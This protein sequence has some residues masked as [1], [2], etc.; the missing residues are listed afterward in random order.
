MF[1]LK[2]VMFWYDTSWRPLEDVFSITISCLPR[3][4]IFRPQDVLKTSWRRFKD[5]LETFSRRI[6]NALKT[7]WSCL[8]RKKNCHDLEKPFSYRNK[9]NSNNNLKDKQQ[10]WILS[11]YSKVSIIVP[12]WC[13]TKWFPKFY[14]LLGACIQ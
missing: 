10:S 11:I 13:Q 14:L 6:E 12:C 3:C 2:I 4:T 5:V 8:E 1:L 9:T 7:S